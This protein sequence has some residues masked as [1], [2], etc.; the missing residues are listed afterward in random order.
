MSAGDL[1]LVQT[2][3][4]CP[5]Q[6]DVYRDGEVVGYLRLRHGH[7][8]AQLFDP[9]GPLV[10]ESTPRGDGIFEDDERDEYLRL[11]VNAVQR[12]LEQGPPTPPLKSFGVGDEYWA[13]QVFEP[14][15]EWC[16]VGVMIGEGAGQMHTPLMFRRREQIDQVRGVA[17]SHSRSTGQ[18]LRLAHFTLA[19]AEDV[20]P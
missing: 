10:Y 1:S 6:Y 2:C 19:D 11:A 20:T 8:T 5:E 9:N 17:E 16:T 3:G 18:P 7:F 13:W 15:G 14:T 4:A 12:A